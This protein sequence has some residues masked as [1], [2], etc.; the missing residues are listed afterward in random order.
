METTFSL[1]LS[2]LR[3]P[4]SGPEGWTAC[5]RVLARCGRQS[6]AQAASQRWPFVGPGESLPDSTTS[7]HSKCICKVSNVN[8]RAPARL[9]GGG[10]VCSKCTTSP[11]RPLTT[12]RRAWPTDAA[13]IQTRPPAQLALPLPLS[14]AHARRLG[15]RAWQ[16]LLGQRQRWPLSLP[17]PP[18][19]L[20]LR[21]PSLVGRRPLARRRQIVS[22]FGC[23][24]CSR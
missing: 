17:P 5:L 14:V 15:R 22:R 18:P 6:N 11:G 23:A 10:K 3:L 1:S 8:E 12:I 21:P 24:R 2:P 16:Q 4:G 7:C 13:S 19:P 20:K 9:G